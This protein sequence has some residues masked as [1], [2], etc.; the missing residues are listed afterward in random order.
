LKQA[1]D[2]LRLS[3]QLNEEISSFES[4]FEGIALVLNPGKNT[5]K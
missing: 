1:Y 2:K 3:R 5:A 4:M